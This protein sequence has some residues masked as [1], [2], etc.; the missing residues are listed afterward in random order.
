MASKMQIF[1]ASEALTQADFEN[2]LNGEKEGKESVMRALRNVSPSI[3]S[4]G[5][6]TQ[7][8]IA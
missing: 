1:S 4:F 3:L 6:E 8:S 5:V 2:N 7:E